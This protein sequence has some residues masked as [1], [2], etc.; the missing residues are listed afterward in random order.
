MG[1]VKSVLDRDIKEP[2][3]SEV[4]IQRAVA[5]VIRL[6]QAMPSLDVT[7]AEQLAWTS[8]ALPAFIAAEQEMYLAEHSSPIRGL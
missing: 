6:R 7:E 2:R 5:D 3:V 8:A 4:V 1:D